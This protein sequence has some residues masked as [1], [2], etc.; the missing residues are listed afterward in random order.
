MQMQ[1]QWPRTV[2]R[3]ASLAMTRQGV[4]RRRVQTAL[5][6]AHYDDRYTVQTRYD[7]AADVTYLAELDSLAA[8]RHTAAP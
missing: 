3:H 4:A 6:S 7:S 8:S 2:I 1:W 5:K